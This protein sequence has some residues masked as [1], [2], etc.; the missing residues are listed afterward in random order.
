MFKLLQSTL[1][2]R[3]CLQCCHPTSDIA[4]VPPFLAQ[5]CK[6]YVVPSTPILLRVEWDQ[7]FPYARENPSSY[8]ILV[9]R[10]S[11]ITSMVGRI[12]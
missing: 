8:C 10:V 11:C 2:A 1:L 7:V 6:V 12:R 5:K 9:S 4:R 3:D